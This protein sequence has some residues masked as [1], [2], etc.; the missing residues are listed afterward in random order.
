MNPKEFR[1][2]MR[3]QQTPSEAKL[4]YALRAKRFQH[5]KFRRQHTID[6][7]TVDFY[8]HAFRLVIELDGEVHNNS[9]Q[10]QYDQE[11]D[12]TL[13]ELGYRV[14]RFKNEEIARSMETVLYAIE[15]YIKEDISNNI[16]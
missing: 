7:Y 1:R 5:I 4:W 9:G 15:Q 11:R 10:E 6:K 12:L 14:L 3:R 16:R 13:R 2:E 8:C